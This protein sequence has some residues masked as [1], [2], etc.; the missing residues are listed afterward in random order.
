MRGIDW[1]VAKMV[2]RTPREK[3]DYVA[4]CTRCGGRGYLVRT[5]DGG[6]ATDGPF[7]YEIA[8]YCQLCPKCGYL[9][10]TPNHELGC[11][12]AR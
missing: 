8:C 10:D 7:S 3:R 5:A 9:R 12:H 1:T 4:T 11:A 2:D 6:G